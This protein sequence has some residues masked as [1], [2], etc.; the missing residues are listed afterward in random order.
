MKHFKRNLI[1]IIL[2]IL[3]LIIILPNYSGIANCLFPSNS[4]RN[5]ELIKLLLSIEGGIGI[6]FGLFVS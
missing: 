6:L 1:W 4:D 5:G 2:L 3:P